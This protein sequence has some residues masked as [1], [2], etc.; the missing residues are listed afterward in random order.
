[1]GKA[2]GIGLGN[3]FSCVAAM[4]QTGYPEVIPNR[5]G[6]RLTP[7]VVRIISGREWVVGSDVHSVDFKLTE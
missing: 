7:S 5:E 4:M 3:R 1:M 6:Q 2:I